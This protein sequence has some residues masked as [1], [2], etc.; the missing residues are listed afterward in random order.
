MKLHQIKMFLHSKG[1]HQQQQKGQTTKWGK[2][3]SDDTS[4]TGLI[5]KMY[6]ELI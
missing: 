2:I 4:D 5:S 6:N 1:N 3:L